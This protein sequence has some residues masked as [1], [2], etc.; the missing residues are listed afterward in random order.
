M[1]SDLWSYNVYIP[2]NVALA[3]VFMGC[4]LLYQ[5]LNL[6]SDVHRI[7]LSEVTTWGNQNKISKKPF[8]VS[9]KPL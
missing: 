3:E 2:S 6:L 8:T 9:I 1:T 4:S 5:Q 7:L